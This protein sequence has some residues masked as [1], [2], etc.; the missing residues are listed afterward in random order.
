[1]YFED[2]K[3]LGREVSLQDLQTDAGTL[4]L[5][6][7]FTLEDNA[8]RHRSK[9]LSLWASVLARS[10][11]LL[12]DAYGFRWHNV[13]HEA[14]LLIDR[15]AFAAMIE[16]F[17]EEF[18]RTTASRFRTFGNIA[19]EHMYPH[20]MIAK[21]VATALPLR[22]VIRDTGYVSLE[23]NA[24]LNALRLARL[25]RRRPKFFCLN[26][27]YGDA[28]NAAA[29]ARSG[30]S[31]RSST[32]RPRSSSGSEGWRGAHAYPATA[33]LRNPVRSAGHVRDPRGGVRGGA[34]A[35]TRSLRLAPRAR[36]GPNR[37]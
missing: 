15:D 1:V 34:R 26:D 27:N 16:R 17:G 28:P 25:R 32:P 5:Y 18:G 21:G 7:R 3:L 12:N 33:R 10:N 37:P 2:D 4:R 9:R 8:W 24:L 19:A 23:N 11:R 20:Y 6:L 29:W 31:S 36:I 22:E 30:T 14:P 35:S 13:L